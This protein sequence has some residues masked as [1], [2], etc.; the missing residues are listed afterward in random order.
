MENNNNNTIVLFE[1]A[2]GLA[3][4]LKSPFYTGNVVVDGTKYQVAVWK[5]ISKAGDEYLSG[6]I[7][8]ITANE[9]KTAD[10]S[11]MFQNRGVSVSTQEDDLPF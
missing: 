8:P 11:Q 3:K 1:N 5:R 10:D 9:Y 7:Q 6:T 4:N 2:K